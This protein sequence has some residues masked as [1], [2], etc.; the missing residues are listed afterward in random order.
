MPAALLNFPLSAVVDGFLSY[1]QWS[2]S[3]HEIMASEYIWSPDD[4]K[5]FIR[6]SAPFVIDNQKP[7]SAPFIVV[8]RGAYSFAN[9]T[10]DNLK[11]AT[12]NTFDVPEYSDWMDGY[13]NVICGSGVAGEASSLANFCAIQIHANRK[14]IMETL[15]FVR[16][17]N[18]VDVGPEIPVSKD[19]EVR[20]WEVTLR[21]FVS[22]NLQWYKYE[23]TPTLWHKAAFLGI[24]KP[25]EATSTVGSTV[26]SANTLVDTTKNFGPLIT[27]IPQLL[28]SELAK[29]YY[30]IKFP[31]SDYPGALYP[32]ASVV[33]NHTIT[34]LDHDVNNT[35]VPWSAPSTASD[36]NYEVWWNEAHIRMEIPK[37]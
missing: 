9:R 20:R 19:V 6:I 33:D 34:L 7:M 37:I 15:K 28:E 17:L 32:I 25:A 31:N 5:S 29:G 3:N 1:L 23:R 35:P 16:N 8:E 12:P 27:N 4:R 22:M 18:Y 13:V 14:P 26:A 10:I 11:T 36:V 24:A 21:F 2:F 30:Y